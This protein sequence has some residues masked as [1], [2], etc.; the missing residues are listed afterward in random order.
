LIRLQSE[1]RK[2]VALPIAYTQIEQRGS[3]L[4]EAVCAPLF[5]ANSIMD[6]EQPVRIVFSFNFSEARV[7]APPVRVLPSAFEVIAL[8]HIR[9]G[10]RH[11]RTKLTQASINALRSFPACH[12]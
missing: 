6:E 12:N 7:V 11:E 1:P 10:L 9:S 8:A 3:K 2:P 4:R 5:R